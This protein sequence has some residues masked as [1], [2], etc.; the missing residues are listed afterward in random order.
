MTRDLK[1]I[2]SKADYKAALTELESLWGAKSGS[3]RGDRLDVLATLERV[4]VKAKRIRSDG[5]SWRIPR[6]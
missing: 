5:C 2:R 3:P 1:P 4:A 6:E